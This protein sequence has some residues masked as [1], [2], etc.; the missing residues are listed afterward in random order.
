VQEPAAVALI[1]TSKQN[2]QK[3]YPVLTPEAKGLY[4]LVLCV[5][6]IHAGVITEKR[7]FLEEMPP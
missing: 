4:C 1:W 3:L 5:N 2:N 6:L 7:A